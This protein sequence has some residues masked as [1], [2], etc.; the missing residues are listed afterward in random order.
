MEE[1]KGKG[2]R[3]SCVSFIKNPASYKHRLMLNVIVTEKLLCLM[4]S[5]G[6]C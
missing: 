5:R 2:G 4:I 6:I 1:G 3:E